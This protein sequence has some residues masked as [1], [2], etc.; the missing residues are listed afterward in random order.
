MN[1]RRL[2]VLAALGVI[3]AFYFYSTATR[4]GAPLA[5]SRIEAVDRAVYAGRLA[6]ETPMDITVSLKLRNQG[7]L[8]RFLEDLQDPASPVYHQYLSMAE[9]VSRYSPLA[10]DYSAVQAFLRENG[11]AITDTWEN[12]ITVGARGSAEAVERAFGVTM[13]RYV[14]EVREVYAGDGTPRIPDHLAGF[15]D[16]VFGLDTIYQYHT[17]HIARKLDRPDIASTA[18]PLISGKPPY[19]PHELQEIYGL[20]IDPG[21]DDGSGQH[22]AVILWDSNI[23][24]TDLQYLWT[25]AGIAQNINTIKVVGVGASPPAFSGS[26]ADAELAL[27]VQYTSSFIAYST[28]T[29]RSPA[30]AVPASTGPKVTA[31]IA[32]DAYPSSLLKAEQKFVSEGKKTT[33]PKIASLSFGIGEVIQSISSAETAVFQNAAATGLTVCVSSGDDGSQGGAPWGDSTAQASWPASSPYVASIGGT[34]ITVG[35]S[36]GK[37]AWKKEVVWKDGNGIRPSG[38]STGGGSSALFTKPSWQTGTGVPSANQRHVPDISLDADPDTGYAVRFAG[39]WYY[40]GGTSASSP[41]MASFFAGVNQRRKAAGKPYL[42]QVNAAIYSIF[43]SAA[44]SN[45]HDVTSGNNVKYKAQKGYDLC[46]GV[47]TIRGDTLAASLL[48]K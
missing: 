43:N 3:A 38:A 27:D 19:L 11:F 16:G 41:A 1:K 24:K 39:S 32:K 21:V 23:N 33:G 10:E 48:A 9:F 35:K 28:L 20:T 30:S 44:A 29:A 31:Y 34:T 8:E 4:A 40:F 14:H 17:N 7:E 47:G 45:Y 15:V 18:S 12:R 37:L 2:V 5:T 36:A 25:S 42:G 6:G 13:N 26:N 22:V 46:T